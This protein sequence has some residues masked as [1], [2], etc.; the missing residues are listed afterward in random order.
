MSL[1]ESR[2]LLDLLRNHESLSF[3]ELADKLSMSYQTVRR[4]CREPGTP[5]TETIIKLSKSYPGITDSL[6]RRFSYLS[7]V[8]ESPNYAKDCQDIINSALHCSDLPGSIKLATGRRAKAV[9]FYLH[10]EQIS[11][12]TL[13]SSILGKSQSQI[14]RDHIYELAR[15]YLVNTPNLFLDSEHEASD[16]EFAEPDD[17]VKIAE[18]DLTLDAILNPRHNDD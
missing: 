14:I 18:L 15:E 9:S 2:T 3:T 12:L 16:Y 4:M 13:L 10:E 11:A 7:E 17:T 1:E 6:W 5:R 8:P